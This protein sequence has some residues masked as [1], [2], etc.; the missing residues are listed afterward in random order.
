M[1]EQV[2]GVHDGDESVA[3]VLTEEDDQVP[4]LGDQLVQHRT[5]QFLDRVLLGLGQDPL[6]RLGLVHDVACKEKDLYVH[7]DLRK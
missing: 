5:G 3:D 7:N 6:Q 1:S 4:G 2:T